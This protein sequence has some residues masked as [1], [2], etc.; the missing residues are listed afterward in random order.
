MLIFIALDPGD[1][2]YI[3][4]RERRTEGDYAHEKCCRNIMKL[5]S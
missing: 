2:H 3:E 5:K 4:V 1:W